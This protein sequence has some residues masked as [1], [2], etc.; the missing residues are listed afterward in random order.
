MMR[1]LYK[2]GI[3]NTSQHNINRPGPN[4]KMWRILQ[5]PVSAS[6]DEKDVYLTTKLN[7]LRPDPEELRDCFDV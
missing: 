5:S 7:A 2:L 6:Y 3:V 1:Q 4:A